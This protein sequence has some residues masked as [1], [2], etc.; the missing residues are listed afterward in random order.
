MNAESPAQLLQATLGVPLE[1]GPRYEKFVLE[2]LQAGRMHLFEG[3]GL[4]QDQAGLGWAVEQVASLLAKPTHSIQALD[5]LMDTEVPPE[6]TNGH[7][8]QLQQLYCIIL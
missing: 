1:L 8:I 3:R 6:F 7:K 2:F 4:S 5:A